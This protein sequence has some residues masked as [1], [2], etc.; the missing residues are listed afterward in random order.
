MFPGT[1]RVVS[2]RATGIK[3]SPHETIIDIDRSNPL[4]GNRHYLSDVND[5][6][7]RARVVALHA[8]DV[9]VDELRN[10]PIS[11]LLKDHAKRVISGEQIAY[12][13]W[14]APWQ[15]HGDNYIAKV[16]ALVAQ[17]TAS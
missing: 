7:Q 4:L 13:C 5:T 12:R 15:C 8:H 6:Q 16:K 11:A 9:E 10:G 3:A 1:I 2:K 17:G 14:C